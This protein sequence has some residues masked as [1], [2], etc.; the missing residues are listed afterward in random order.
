MTLIRE[1]FASSRLL[2]AGYAVLDDC[3]PAEPAAAIA[4]ALSRLRGSGQLRKNRFGFKPPD[5]AAP[6]IL[7][8]PHIFEAELEDAPVQAAAPDLV[9]ALGQLELP[10]AAACSFPELQLDPDGVTVKLQCNEG[11]G[12][13]FPLHFDNAGPPSRRRLSILCYFNEERRAEGGSGAL[14]PSLL[15]RLAQSRS[16]GRGTAASSSSLPGSASASCCRPPTAA[17]SSSFPTECAQ[18][19]RTHTHARARAHTHTHTRTH[20]HTSTHTRSHPLPSRTPSMLLRRGASQTCCL[21]PRAAK[22][23]PPPSPRTG[24]PSSTP[25]CRPPLLPHDLVRRRWLQRGQR[26]PDPDPARDHPLTRDHP[27]LP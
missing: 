5:S 16:G 12:G 2:E 25:L 6:R 7:T 23:S 15:M 4:A 18:P 19:T 8:K 3:L 14:Q 9:S 27:I 26:P 21:L 13:C 17:S 22:M 11:H 24:P 10:Q 1:R 20:T